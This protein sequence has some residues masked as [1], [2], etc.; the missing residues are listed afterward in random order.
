MQLDNELVEDIPSGV[1]YLDKGSGTALKYLI[2]GNPEDIFQQFF[3][4]FGGGG[5]GFED[6]FMGGM[7]GS[8]FAHMGG[9]Q[10]YPT[11]NSNPLSFSDLP[12]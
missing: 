8:P 10:R 7:G 11:L 1:R 3:G 9:G 6:L 12:L 2:A 4:S 5:G